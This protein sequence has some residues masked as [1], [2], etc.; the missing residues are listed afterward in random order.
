MS[1]FVCETIR[2]TAITSD[3][4]CLLLQITEQKE[5][6]RVTSFISAIP[7]IDIV[8]NE[9]SCAHSGINLP[10]DFGSFCEV[11]MISNMNYR[12]HKSRREP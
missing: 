1:T 3:F 7:F 11:C 12:P 4:L 2:K 6:Y 9:G 8:H 10:N 5:T